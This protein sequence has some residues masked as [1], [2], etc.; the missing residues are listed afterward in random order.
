[1]KVKI[2]DPIVKNN[3][4]SIA[5]SIYKQSHGIILVFDISN[6]ESCERL[7]NW[8]TEIENNADATSEKFLIANKL[9]PNEAHLTKEEVIEMTK[10]GFIFHETSAITKPVVDKMF[11][12]IIKSTYSAVKDLEPRKSF[13]LQNNK[14][15]KS[16]CCD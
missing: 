3:N 2:W 5:K 4:L 8:V 1:M 14:K 12:S 6:K 16:G 7:N 13:Q 10:F 11:K 15:S 9:N